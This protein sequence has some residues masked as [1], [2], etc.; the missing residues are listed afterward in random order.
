MARMAVAV[1][2]LASLVAVTADSAE[3]T[4]ARLEASL[5]VILAEAIAAASTAC[6]AAA[7]AAAAA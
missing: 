1:T 5:V 4:D 6:A 3:V 7:F 2:S